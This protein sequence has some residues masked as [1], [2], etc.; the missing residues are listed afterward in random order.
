MPQSP[1]WVN[2]YHVPKVRNIKY[3]PLFLVVCWRNGMLTWGSYSAPKCRARAFEMAAWLI[4]APNY[5]IQ[6]NVDLPS[7]GNFKLYAGG[8]P[9]SS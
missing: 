7:I 4:G 2:P 1:C 5:S 6:S 3:P 8:P 9:Q